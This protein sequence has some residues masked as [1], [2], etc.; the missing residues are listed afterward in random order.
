MPES[1]DHQRLAFGALV[2]GVCSYSLLQSMTVPA[3]PHIRTSLGA[4]QAA[5]SWVLTAFLISASVA[6][7]IAGRVGDSWGKVRVLVACLLLLSLGA[8]GAIL[9]TNLAQMVVARVVQGLAGGVLPL[10]FGIVRDL[11]PAPAS[12]SAGRSSPTSATACSSSSRRWPALPRPPA[13]LG[14]SRGRSAI[15]VR[16]A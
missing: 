11:L 5:A 3:L 4:D 14:S 7:P 12:S 8:V 15:T 1:R 16:C 10:A 13:S 2:V 6:T 9:A